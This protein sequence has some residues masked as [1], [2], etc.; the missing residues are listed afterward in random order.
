MHPDGKQVLRPLQ[1]ELR[2]HYACQGE[3]ALSIQPADG[4]ATP[5]GSPDEITFANLPEW[6][7]LSC[8]CRACGRESR[9]NR[10]VLVEKFGANQ[11]ILRLTRKLRCSK[12]R[13]RD[14]NEIKVGKVKR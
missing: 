9:L 12:C 11:P 14:G 3:I 8:R 13:N 1:V 4:A 10:H 6:Y 7:E 2:K 5:A